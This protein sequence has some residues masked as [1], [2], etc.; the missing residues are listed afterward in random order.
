MVSVNSAGLP[1]PAITPGCHVTL[2]FSLML[3]DG[4]V[5]DS[6]FEREPAS[7]RMGDGSL[8]PGFEQVL[9][10]LTIGAEIEARLPPASAF[11]EPNPGNVQILPRERF[12]R[13][14]DDEYAALVPGAVVAFRDAGGFDLPGVIKEVSS[15][16]ATVDFNH[17]LAGREIVF[18]ARIVSIIPAGT[19][20]VTVKA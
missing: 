5:V 13:F 16:Q 2:H 11:G 9:V 3:E 18:R 4:A 19:D 8:L 20:P 15:T 6:N 17:P 7:F 10:G 1:E 12:A 14:L